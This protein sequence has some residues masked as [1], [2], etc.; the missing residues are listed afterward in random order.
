MLFKNNPRHGIKATVPALNYKSQR[1]VATHYENS[2]GVKSAQLWNL[3]PKEINSI[4]TLDLLKPSL[5]KFLK[6]SP[7]RLRLKDTPLLT[8]THSW[9]GTYKKTPV[10]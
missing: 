3:L 6:N 2:F 4:S 8:T 10:E 7:T 9:N 5:A 1:S